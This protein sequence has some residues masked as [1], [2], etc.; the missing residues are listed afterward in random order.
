MNSLGTLSVKYPVYF[1]SSKGYYPSLNCDCFD[2]NRNALTTSN[3]LPG[4]YHPPCKS[5]G[6]LKSFA[7]FVPGEHYL[8]LWSFLRILRYGG[9]L[10]HPSGSYLFSKYI[11]PYCKSVNYANCGV[12][13]IDQNWFGAKFRK[14][15]LIF[16]F[17]C[18]L[19]DIPSF[20]LS[21]NAITHSVSGSNKS[22]F[23]KNSTHLE[24]IITPLSLNLFLLSICDS[25]YNKSLH[26]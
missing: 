21:F 16:Y 23:L 1:I 6:K 7:N 9:V 5:W 19:I 11:I 25:I 26:D 13:S 14:R 3:Y 17:G 10:E 22:S 4:V 8:G 15:T 20:P 2:I 12:F 24:R 18:N